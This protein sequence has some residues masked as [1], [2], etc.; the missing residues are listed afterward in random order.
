M[1]RPLVWAAWIW[2][3]GTAAAA[4]GPVAGSGAYALLGFVALAAAAAWLFELPGRRAAVCALLFSAAFCRYEWQDRHNISQLLP[5]GIAAATADGTEV[6]VRGTISSPVEVDGDRASFTLRV[7]AIEANEWPDAAAGSAGRGKQAEGELVQ[8][9]VRL[10][11]QAEQDA[12]A[13]WQRGDAAAFAG[14][15]RLPSVARNF[16]GF[17]YRNY[18]RLQHVHWLVYVKGTDEVRTS[19]P[20]HWRPDHVLRWNDRLRAMLGG[21]LDE[22]FPGDHGG[23]MKSLLLG[24]REELDPQQFKQFSELGLTHILAISGMHVAVFVGVLLWL[25]RRAGLAK[26]TSLLVCMCLLP[27]Y[28]LLTGASPSIV[29]AG[30]MGMMGLYLAR[31]NLLKDGQQM[32][33][34]AALIML[35]WEPYDLLDVGFQLSF[36]VTWGLIVGVPKIAPLLPSRPVWLN[37]ALTVAVTAQ[38]VSFPVSV[39]YFNQFSLLSLPANLLLVPLISTIVTPLGSIALILS[40]V[41]PLPAQWLAKLAVWLNEASFW[42]IG[43]MNRWPVARL[44]WP[45]PPL[46]WIAA[47]YVLCAWLI[48]V[49][50]ERKREQ[51]ER[52]SGV[53]LR[54]EGEGRGRWRNIQLA[55]AAV[56]LVF[57][58]VYGYKPETWKGRSTAI[59]SFLD[60]GQGDAALIQTP[61]RK[62]VLS[63]GGGTISFRKSGEEWKERRDPYEVGRKLLVPLLKQRGAHRLEYVIISHEDMDHIGGLQAVLEDIPVGGILFNGTVK[64]GEAVKK[65][66]RTALAKRIPLIPV[67]EGQTFRLDEDTVLRILNPPAAADQEPAVTVSAEQNPH[68]VVFH[69]DMLGSTFLFTGDI[70]AQGERDILDRIGRK[71][72]DGASFS[73]FPPIDVLKVAHHGSKTSTG[74][75]WLNRWQPKFAVISVGINNIYRHPSREVVERLAAH[76]SEVL[77]TDQHGEVRFR[78]VPGRLSMETVLLP[79]PSKPQTSSSS[80]KE[81]GGSEAN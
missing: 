51:A 55:A 15:L 77:R 41:A 70:H 5:S 72:G 4:V 50:W 32:I 62:F 23:Y 18:L 16:G 13:V 27:G 58:L 10:L 80:R 30:L 7:A 35:F 74:D 1:N 34:A 2:V 69:L 39:Y 78:L 37:G 54:A 60:V 73:A 9:S 63:D 14:T 49:C 28:V 22:L 29:R 75:E 17:D 26:E 56:A 21:K 11:K 46:W 24:I 57:L 43:F 6:F 25:M 66:F 42:A 53:W 68:A 71:V 47:Y 31:R 44:I 76:G 36:L 65:L 33:A 52:E 61:G 45:S 3:A 12:A 20:A 40:F 59:V 64:P 38:L 48:C 67:H 81:S 19:P 79:P 8:V